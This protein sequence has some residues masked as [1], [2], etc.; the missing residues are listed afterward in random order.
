MCMQKAQRAGFRRVS[1]R[2]VPRPGRRKAS[3]LHQDSDHVTDKRG[4]LIIP[5]G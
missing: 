1:L 2:S 3:V 5:R 4:E